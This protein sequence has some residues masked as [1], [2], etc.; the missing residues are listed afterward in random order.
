[1]AII[2][3]AVNNAV[4]ITTSHIMVHNSRYHLLY[5]SVQPF[6][7]SAISFADTHSAITYQ[8]T[9]DSQSV[10]LASHRR[11]LPTWKSW[12]ASGGSRSDAGCQRQISLLANHFSRNHFSRMT[13]T[14][15]S[16]KGAA[17]YYLR[18]G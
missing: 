13:R 10:L 14:L 5:G 3:D 6:E 18:D 1:M 4:V 11:S 9:A 2:N 12:G 16:K 8:L 17:I 7:I 15:R